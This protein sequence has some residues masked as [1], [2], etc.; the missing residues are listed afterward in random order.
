MCRLQAENRLLGEWTEIATANALKSQWKKKNFNSFRSST[1][2]QSRAVRPRPHRPLTPTTEK[3]TSVEIYVVTPK[4]RYWFNVFSPYHLFCVLFSFP[5]PALQSYPSFLPIITIL[6]VYFVDYE[7]K[8]MLFPK[9]R[10]RLMPVSSV[11]GQWY[12]IIS[13]SIFQLRLLL[14][15]FG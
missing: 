10:D 2:P 12:V 7:G 14:T 5:S 9:K 4:M 6:A 3:R 11:R 13:R 15:A 1:R 8:S